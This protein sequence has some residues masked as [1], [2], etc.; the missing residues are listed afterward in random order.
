MAFAEHLDAYFADF[1]VA[2]TL[3]GN[4]VTV[5][6]DNGYQPGLGEFEGNNPLATIKESSIAGV[7]H[8]ASLVIG[9]TSYTVRE[10]QPDGTGLAVLQLRK[11]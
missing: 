2:A 11:V 8:G 3:A 10:I 5:I 4:A 1:G 6:F 9:A 7:V